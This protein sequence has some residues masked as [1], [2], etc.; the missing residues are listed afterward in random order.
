MIK[1]H[2]GM[3]E[4]IIDEEVQK[5]VTSQ[6]DAYSKQLKSYMRTYTSGELHART[7]Q[8]DSESVLHLMPSALRQ[9]LLR[10]PE[11]SHV[12]LKFLIFLEPS[13]ALCDP[14]RIQVMKGSRAVELR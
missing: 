6:I 2:E 8:T 12:M 14:C 4:L 9:V 13:H 1:G 11:P 5:S 10:S 7:I 3:L